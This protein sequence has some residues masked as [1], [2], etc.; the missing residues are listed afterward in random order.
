MEGAAAGKAAPCG[1]ERAGGA[2]AGA[3]PG[4][5]GGLGPRGGGP[6][7][8]DP[9]GRAGRR[10]PRRLG[11]PRRLCGPGPAHPCAPPLVQ[12]PCP[13]FPHPCHHLQPGPC[14]GGSGAVATHMRAQS[15]PPPPPPPVP[16]PI[17]AMPVV[18]R[19]PAWRQPDINRPGPQPTL[20]AARVSAVQL[21]D[22]CCLSNCISNW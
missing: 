13:P 9:P 6:G 16:C 10:R 1:A 7:G 18:C 3:A 20:A 4:L 17:S 5:A 21:A 14:S 11:L 19:T 15:P 2:T 8:G 22:E 12:I